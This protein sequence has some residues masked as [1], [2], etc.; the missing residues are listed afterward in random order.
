MK[1][2]ICLFLMLWL[3]LFT[4]SAWAMSAQ[5]QFDELQST[6]DVSSQDVSQQEEHPC[7]DMQLASHTETPASDATHGKH[8]NGH[9]C[10]ACGVCL[11]ATSFTSPALQHV[12]TPLLSHTKSVSFDETFVSQRYPPALKPPISA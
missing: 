2:F 5:M 3:P 9:D 1:R 12:F 8:C 11:F 4:G 10:F 6:L 7:H